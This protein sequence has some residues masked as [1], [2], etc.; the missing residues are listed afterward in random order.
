MLDKKIKKK[1]LMGVL[2]NEYYTLASTGA[3]AMASIFDDYSNGRFAENLEDWGISAGR[4]L[5][6]INEM[7]DDWL[8]Q[9]KMDIPAIDFYKK[10]K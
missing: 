2:E 3:D 8:N 7:F 9:G 5:Q 6:V 10:R 4:L 1:E